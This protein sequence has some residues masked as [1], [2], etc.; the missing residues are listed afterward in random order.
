MAG[1]PFPVCRETLG[2]LRGMSTEGRGLEMLPLSNFGLFKASANGG[3][4]AFFAH[5]GGFIFG[6]LVTGL[7]TRTR[8]VAPMERW[9]PST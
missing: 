1:P 9:L 7:L 2:L 6:M 4:V 8:R 3:G 5:V